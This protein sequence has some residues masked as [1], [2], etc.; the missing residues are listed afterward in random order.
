MAVPWHNST[1]ADSSIPKV[2]GIPRLLP[3][4]EQSFSCDVSLTTPPF[5]FFP[6][7]AYIDK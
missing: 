7:T 1:I 3:L 4:I 2:T 6:H 5:Y